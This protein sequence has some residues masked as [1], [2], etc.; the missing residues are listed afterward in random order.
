MF[1]KLA[2]ME[3]MN[4]SV[5]E[6]VP[7]LY[8]LTQDSSLLLNI[9]HMFGYTESYILRLKPGIGNSLTLKKS[10]GESSEVDDHIFF[11][12]NDRVYDIPYGYKNM[13]LDD[14]LWEVAYSC[15]LSVHVLEG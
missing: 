11:I 15:N 14:Y 10:T 13:D 3:K 9:L 2:E 8:E 7:R 12:I 4:L 1:S 6:L 5:E